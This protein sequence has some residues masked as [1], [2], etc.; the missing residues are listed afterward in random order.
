MYPDAGIAIAH[1]CARSVPPRHDDQRPRTYGG[2][3]RYLMVVQVLRQAI[4][5]RAYHRSDPGDPEVAKTA[6]PAIRKSPAS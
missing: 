3:S 1:A 5:W 4:V 2:R 6:A